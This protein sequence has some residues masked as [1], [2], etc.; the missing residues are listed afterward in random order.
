M[1]PLQADKYSN[2]GGCFSNVLVLFSTVF[3]Q[4]MYFHG[5]YFESWSK[6]RISLCL[7]S[8]L[9]NLP[10]FRA[11]TR[12]CTTLPPLLRSCSCRDEE[13]KSRQRIGNTVPNFQKSASASRI[14]PQQ[15]RGNVVRAAAVHAAGWLA[16]PV[17]V[18]GE[19]GRQQ[20]IWGRT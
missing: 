6:V 20:Y 12:I 1:S 17:A 7:P 3:H 19:W 5:L 11:D 15:K 8:K 18:A 16:D 4:R 10:T 14:C 2:S 9:T 13:I